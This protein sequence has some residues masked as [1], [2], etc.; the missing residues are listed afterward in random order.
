[1]KVDCR[2]DVVDGRVSIRGHSLILENVHVVEEIGRGANG[3]VF[4]GVDTL[5]ERPIA[6]KIWVQTGGARRNKL[7]Q[8]IFEA[9]KVACL[10]HKNIVTAYN[11]KIHNDELLSLT[12]EY[13]DGIT[14]RVYLKSRPDVTSRLRIWSQ[15]SDAIRY[16]HASGVYHGD[17]HPGNVILV[18]ETPKVIDFGTSIF[19]GKNW[20]PKERESLLLQKLVVEMVPEWDT[21]LLAPSVECVRDKPEAIL[22]QCISW[23]RLFEHYSRFVH[24]LQNPEDD[25]YQLRNELGNIAFIL[26]RCPSI[27]RSRMLNILNKHQLPEPLVKEF[28]YN[29]IDMSKLVLMGPSYFVERTAGPYCEPYLLMKEFEELTTRVVDMYMTIYRESARNYL[30]SIR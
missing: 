17:L 29:C 6:I 13:L 24:Y 20:Q 18:S 28:L 16:A 1:M 11:A 5:L 21:G 12:T 14:L 9:R 4:K 3:V 7:K 2:A 19:A 30:D 10:K 22:H 15:I 26:A 25:H 8:G 23:V 27:S